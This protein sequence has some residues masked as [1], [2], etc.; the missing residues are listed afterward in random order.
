[1]FRFQALHRRPRHGI[2]GTSSGGGP[3]E[4]V[5]A[6]PPQHQERLHSRLLLGRLRLGRKEVDEIGESG[7]AQV[8]LRVVL[9]ADP[10]RVFDDSSGV[11][12]NGVDGLQ[13]QV[14]WS[15]CL[16]DLKIITFLH[17]KSITILSRFFVIFSN[18][19]SFESNKHL[20]KY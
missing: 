1:M 5:E 11:G 6:G 8:V 10:A 14:L 16:Q 9:D 17:Y 3:P 13:V 4:Q 15:V 19:Y 12:R 7:G 2:P 18:L 20:K